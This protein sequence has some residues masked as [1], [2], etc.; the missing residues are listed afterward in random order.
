VCVC[1][2]VVCRYV[3]IYVYICVCWE[4]CVCVVCVSGLCVCVVCV[5]VCAFLAKK[6]GFLEEVPGG[7]IVISRGNTRV[8][9]LQMVCLSGNF[10]PSGLT[11][12]KPMPERPWAQKELT[13]FRPWRCRCHDI[14]PIE[15][16]LPGL[17]WITVVSNSTCKACP[18]LRG[19]PAPWEPVV[20]HCN[21][22]LKWFFRSAALSSGRRQ[23]LELINPKRPYFTPELDWS[24]LQ[25]N[26]PRDWIEGEYKSIFSWEN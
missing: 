16:R 8:S 20:F 25:C 14:A 1:V 5:C 24:T 3:C 12:S 9:Q 2:C 18:R 4:W 13:K 23:V 19:N 11:P 22:Q 7:I 10:H 15:S 17:N 6:W 26:L 21:L